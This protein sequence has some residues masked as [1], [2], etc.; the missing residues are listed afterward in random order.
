[1]NKKRY[2]QVPNKGSWKLLENL[3]N[4]TSRLLTFTLLHCYF[5]VNSAALRGLPFISGIFLPS[6]SE[7]VFEIKVSN[8]GVLRFS[9]PFFYKVR[10]FFRAFVT[11]CRDLAFV[12]QQ[13][14]HYQRFTKH[15]LTSA[16]SSSRWKGVSYGF[17]VQ[18]MYQC[19][20]A[21]SY[22][23]HGVRR[24]E[25]QVGMGEFHFSPNE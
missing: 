19:Q 6:S 12:H 2:H 4:E 13:Q 24:W 23:Y 8:N 21:S 16:T 1:M 7:R 17:S 14:H 9:L 11:L 20:S 5:S 25:G 18:Y 15:I 3:T 10:Q 22:V